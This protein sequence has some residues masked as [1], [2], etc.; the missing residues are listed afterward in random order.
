MSA[1]GV[2][3]RKRRNSGIFETNAGSRLRFSSWCV[4]ALR[5]RPLVCQRRRER[6]VARGIGSRIARHLDLGKFQ[7]AT[8]GV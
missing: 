8:I 3:T 4:A 1:L 7:R 2:P 5:H 6:G